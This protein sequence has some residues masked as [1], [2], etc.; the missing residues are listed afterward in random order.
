MSGAG[1]RVAAEV[2]VRCT[3]EK[4]DHSGA[5]APRLVERVHVDEEG[6]LTREVPEPT[7][8]GE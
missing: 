6:C 4:Y 7:E 5:G 2:R 1:D 3:V 8:R